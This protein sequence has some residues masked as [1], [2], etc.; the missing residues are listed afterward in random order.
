VRDV[1]HLDAEVRPIGSPASRTPGGGLGAPHRVVGLGVAGRIHQR[2]SPFPRGPAKFLQ[3]RFL[4]GELGGIALA[5]LLVARR[6]VPERLLGEEVVPGADRPS[7]RTSGRRGFP[8]RGMPSTLEVVERWDLMSLPPSTEKRTPRDPGPDAPRV[9]KRDGWIPRVLFTSPECRAIV[10]DLESGEAMG[11]H[12]VRERAVVQVVRGRVS[13]G[14]P[15]ELVEC[16]A[17]TLVNF[18]P[19][20]A[21]DI[22]ALTGARLLLVLA[23]WPAE[24]H[25]A[26][27]EAERAQQL[28]PNAA[29]EP[30]PVDQ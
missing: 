10:V 21:H 11:D 19:G 14:S 5:E 27:A 22:R 24:E 20:E 4:F 3:L 23:P 1:D 29:V 15:G 18:D 9:P 26:D 28:P 30:L 17:G 13:I 7:W 2:E 6:I 25:Y 12:Q 16:D 8:G